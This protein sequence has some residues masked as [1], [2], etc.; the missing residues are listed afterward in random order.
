MARS[1]VT[2]GHCFRI[3]LRLVEQVEQRFLPTVRPC[4]FEPQTVSRRLFEAAMSQVWCSDIRRRERC[5]E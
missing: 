5:G 3:R 2:I 4:F 1:H